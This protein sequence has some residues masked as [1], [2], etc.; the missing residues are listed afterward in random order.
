MYKRR[1]KAAA[2]AVTAAL[3]AYMLWP[4][5]VAAI[6]EFLGPVEEEAAEEAAA[7]EAP[8]EEVPPGEEAVAEEA[9]GQR[10]LPFRERDGWLDVGTLALAD[11]LGEDFPLRFRSWVLL[12]DLEPAPWL[13]DWREIARAA[14]YYYASGFEQPF[15]REL[16]EYSYRT[17]REE[18][19]FYA[20]EQERGLIPD[21]ELGRES[22][23]KFEG[24][25][26]FTAGFS[27]TTY[28]GGSQFLEGEQPAA[29]ITMEGELQLRIEGTV[30][31]KTHV[32]VDYDDTRENETRNQVSV[33]YKGDPDEFVQEAAFGDI[34]LS[35]PATD[36]VSY[37]SSRAVFGAKV[38]LKYKWARLMAVAS[39]EKGE[40]EKATFTGGAELTSLNV[41]DTGYTARRFF[42]LNTYY[43][44]PP[45]DKTYFE[46]YEGQERKIYKENNVPK[47]EVF[48]N[49]GNVTGFPTG[50]PR[51]YFNAYEFDDSKGDGED[52]INGKTFI[53]NTL[54]SKKLARGTDYTVDVEKGIITFN[55]TI[56]KEDYL[57]V[58][59]IVANGSNEPKNIIGYRPEGTSYILDVNESNVFQRDIKCIK[60]NKDSSV[61]ER[62]ERRNY[63]FLGSTN[64]RSPSLVVKILD[65]TGKEYVEGESYLYLYGLDQDKDG[66][67]DAG[68]LDSTNS[69]VIVPD[70]VI[71]NEEFKRRVR[72]GFLPNLPFDYDDNGKVEG[73]DAYLP[74]ID[75]QRT[76]HF[77]YSS[78]KPSFFLRPNI[79]PGSET[80]TLNGRVLVPNQDYWLD[81]DSGFLE[82]LAEGADDPGAV[83][84]VTYEYKPFFAL[85]T[86]SLVAGRFQ[87]GPDDDRFLGT[88]LV[89]EFST[90][91]PR[92]VIPKIEEAP[93]DHLIFDVDGR[94]RFYPEFLTRL[95]DAV[96][97]AHTTEGSAVDVEAEF[98]RS[99]KDVNTVG[100]AMIDDMEGARQLSTVSM[101][102]TSW[103]HAS[104]P[105][106]AGLNQENRGVAL[107]G[108]ESKQRL[109]SD[110]YADWP[111]DTLE[112]LE[113]TKL[114]GNPEGNR[115]WGGIHRVISPTG[116]DFTE[117]RFENVEIMMK[118]N[119][120]EGGTL[121]LDLGTVDE[122]ADGNSALGQEKL[123]DGRL[124]TEN[125][126]GYEFNN[127][128]D[129]TEPGAEPPDP[130]GR[131]DTPIDNRNIF[132]SE[133]NNLNDR[134]DTADNYFTYDIPLDEVLNRRSPYVIRGPKDPN[135][136]LNAGWYI[137]RVP[138]NFDVADTEGQPD[139]TGIQVLRFWFEAQTN[140][141]F[142]SAS[143]VIMATVSFAA[144]RWDKPELN[145]DKGLNEMK[146]S[147]KDSRH[148]ADYVPLRKVEDPET[149]TIEREQAL[150]MEYVLTDWEDVGVKSE[151]GF[152]VWGAGNDEYDTED[153]NH[154]GILDPGE[155]IG[156]GPYHVG[157]ANGR[158]DEEGAPEGST[159]YTT[160]QGQ[161]YTHYRKMRLYYFNRTPQ[162][163]GAPP[164][165]NDIFFV[166]FGADENNYYEYLTQMRGSRE[167]EVV[168][169]DLERFLGLQAKG[170][171]FIEADEAVVHEHYRVVGDPSLINVV[172]TRVGVRTKLPRDG[173]SG[174]FLAYREVWVNDILLLEPE[175]LIGRAM[176]VRT[177][178]D[179]GNFVKLSGG[180][181]NVTS[182]FEEIGTTSTARS[183]TTGK[184]AEATLELAKFMPDLWNARMPLSGAVSEAETITEEK[185]DPKRS[186]Y[187]QGRTVGVSRRIAV[188]FSKYK[189]PSGDFSFKNSD[190]V[191]YKYGRTVESDIYAGGIDYEV[192][193]RKRY[194]PTN[195]RS[196]FDRDFRKT[197]YAEE[198]LQSTNTDWVT[199]D[200][201]SSVKFEP[202]EDLEVTPSY[203]YEY[204]RDRVDKTEE[205]FDETYGLRANYFYVKGLRPGTSYTS[206][207]REIVLL[208]TEEQ[209]P[210]MD[211][212]PNLGQ[213]ESLDMSLSTSYNFSVPVD[214]G[215]LTGER[216]R[217][218][219]KWSVTPSYDLVRSSS[220]TDMSG[221]APMWYRIG[222]NYV[223][224]EF[225]DNYNKYIN[226]RRRY[227]ITVNNRF[228]PLEFLGY[229]EGT[230]WENWDFIQT[231]F[232]FSYSN[233][234]SIITGDPFRTISTT[235]PD[236]TCQLYGVKNFPLVAAY[237]NRSTL[238]IDYVRRRV[239]QQNNDVEVQQKPGISWRA[240]WTRNFRT[241]ADYYYTHTKTQD[242]DPNTNEPTGD[243]HLL[244]EENPTLILY[245]DVANPHGFKVPLL[246]TLRW[247]NELNLTA[248]VSFTRVRGVEAT[249]DDTD[250]WEYTVSG[251]YYVTTNLR[252]DV[253]GT[254][255]RFKNYSGVAQD[256]MTIG[257][258]GNFEIIF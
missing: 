145:P 45:T 143:S 223:L 195:I 63:Y 245:Y 124:T 6:D 200:S 58:A 181:R 122:D 7:E 56:R 228:H 37:S 246:G 5:W 49:Y 177:S 206:S 30:L 219:N 88:T 173:G 205:S 81:Y 146:I 190:S 174:G 92:D 2:W 220:Y 46:R 73:K 112:V 28:P 183:T 91:P 151:E 238:V 67:V 3:A 20:W 160:Y 159:R 207:Y 198:E 74:T 119:G 164:S 171:P 57:A 215:K 227:S 42:L 120:V 186:I 38:D 210:T 251:G 214:V 76:L 62:Y 19:E 157:A 241:R 257:I 172:E 11:E 15:D 256:Y 60:E 48:V 55:T 87:F 4:A 65:K 1:I 129:Q 96:P 97:G 102:D 32:Y 152:V 25:K 162:D 239:Y 101:K 212:G 176:R 18:E 12:E 110:V 50:V 147:T 75:S 167:W 201:R 209:P 123:V 188:A 40:T 254:V 252:A 16:M 141:D 185:F 192:Y 54:P 158:L 59:Y 136:P 114:P 68:Y 170:Q 78:D 139:A 153:A 93:A 217:G 225:A 222:R 216:A 193:P 135:A 134:L 64:I 156:V 77:E 137:L 83:L 66:R 236:V 103:K 213:F 95:A 258:N 221:R 51:Y 126:V 189:L 229:R 23:I 61:I 230:K 130:S 125:D 132:D 108:L 27:K 10:L 154:N 111:S 44:P 197:T 165:D 29:D 163:R 94:Y 234:L 161:D 187:A 80:V 224:P 178:L 211:R 196:D 121:H 36:F 248:G 249:Q 117:S 182:G 204:A 35:L 53:R 142:P 155:D 86:K 194:L 127:T 179:F 237:L 255:T 70:V 106:D 253:T 242:I 107:L 26:L 113:I 22:D 98:A 21:I 240:T 203:D 233:E 47:I 33:V 133:D 166:R 69:Y 131:I 79:I 104:A 250:E 244:K 175:A 72:H 13:G 89:A 17:M 202:I 99:R 169:V 144:M 199:D 43:D 41:F 118:L 100:E 39:R 235:F 218:I 116:L 85:L 115:K 168:T 148:D 52:K 226:S 191:S 84:E 184:N 90:K 231:D 109:L 138:L 150:V 8:A 140:D 14:R 82:I 149:K 9:E 180:F 24:R 208:G 31:R 71:I 105:P 247:R 128:P 243:V 34:M 232:D